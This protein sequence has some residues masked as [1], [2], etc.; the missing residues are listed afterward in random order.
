MTSAKDSFDL[1]GKIAV[2]TGGGR[3][4]GKA[5]A[6][7][8]ARRGASS[9]VT[10]RSKDLLK[11]VADEIR[12]E[13]G[14]AIVICGD[15]G[16]EADVAHLA[17]QT[18]SELGSPDILVNNAG[19]NSIYK[20]AE[21][22]TLEEWN[23]II[24]VN[25]TGVF[26]T[27]RAFGRLMLEAGGGSI[28]NMSSIGGRV[29]LRKTAAYCASKGGVELL[30]RSLALD[31]AEKHV[32][33]N[34]ISPGYVETDLTRGLVDHPTLGQR[35]VDRTP[36]SRFGTVEDLT[37]AAVFLASDASQYVTGQTIGVDGGWTAG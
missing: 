23:E 7:E 25:L 32:R 36:M 3:G 8:L 31:W 17:D 29:G 35:I 12:Q 16:S 21:D 6:L 11:A 15:I 28:I 30:T 33:V 27:C 2:V 26:L 4:I 13:G 20:F 14:S 18:L 24:S 1:T 22:T 9:V 10:G 37:G 19:I 5:I 34:C